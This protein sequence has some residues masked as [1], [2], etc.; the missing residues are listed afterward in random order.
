MKN[1]QGFT[2]V[3]LMISLAM[4]GIIVAAVY[5]T[6]TFLQR[7]YTA[8]DRVVEAQQN[9]RAASLTLVQEIRMAGFDP[10]ET[11]NAA[12]EKAY[13]DALYFT[14]D[15][16]EDGNLNLGGDDEDE[17]IAF[18]LY[19]NAVGNSVL[20]LV[21]TNIAVNLTENPVGSGHFEATGHQPIAEHIEAIEFLYTLGDNTTPTAIPPGGFTSTQLANIRSITISI[22]ARAAQ[23]D[24]K[25]INSTVYTPSSGTVWDL[26]GAV[27][28]TGQPTNDNYRRRLLITTVQCRNMGI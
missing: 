10:L 15:R 23:R 7:T 9:I 24:A 4:T 25:F 14:V 22:L 13:S 2:L 1:N 3:E 16:N 12:I 26:N 17:F 6:Y 5:S 11:S 28:G 27:A 18:D 19:T 21:R 8:Q 20:G